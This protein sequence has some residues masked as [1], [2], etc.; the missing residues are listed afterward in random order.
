MDKQEPIRYTPLDCKET[1]VE[2][3]KLST[4]GDCTI[5]LT[6]ISSLFVL[7]MY[8]LNLIFHVQ[9]LLVGVISWH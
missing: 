9:S 3:L 1:D 8:K 4:K 5:L 2:L 6:L 7:N